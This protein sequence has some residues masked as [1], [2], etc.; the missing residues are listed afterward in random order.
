[1]KTQLFIFLL[2][3]T[4]GLTSSCKKKCDCQVPSQL[5]G[6]W[7]MS[8]VSGG[9]AGIDYTYNP[10]EV[11]WYF[12]QS[13]NTLYVSNNLDSTDAKHQYTKLETGTY[14]YQAQSANGENIILVNGISLGVYYF[15][16]D[17]LLLDDGVASDGMLTE[18]ER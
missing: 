2:V 6:R 14:Y 10:G 4:F 5:E 15:E 12:Q 16:Q 9:L 17:K 7:Q 13:N 18:F 8:R 1:M 3:S 11:N